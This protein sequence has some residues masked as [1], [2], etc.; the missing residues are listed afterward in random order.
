MAE[1]IIDPK[2][3]QAMMDVAKNYERIAKRAEGRQDD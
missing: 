3:K 2:A 1:Q